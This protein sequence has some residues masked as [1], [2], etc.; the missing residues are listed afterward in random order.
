MFDISLNGSVGCIQ[1]IVQ[2]SVLCICGMDFRFLML[3]KYQT[4]NLVAGASKLE[5]IQR[6][7][8]LWISVI[9]YF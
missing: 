2:V 4:G 9:Y 7:C 1:Y 8:F 6:G 3:C 5:G